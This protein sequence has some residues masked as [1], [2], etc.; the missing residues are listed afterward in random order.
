[1]AKIA[2]SKL[3]GSGKRNT[4]TRSKN[5]IEIKENSS[6]TES[7]ASPIRTSPRR[8]KLNSEETIATTSAEL[9]NKKRDKPSPPLYDADAENVGSRSE[10]TKN[11]RRNSGNL[12]EFTE[13]EAVLETTDSDSKKRS[14]RRK[15]RNDKYK[16]KTNSSKKYQIEAES[17]DN[18]MVEDYVE[19]VREEEKEVVEADQINEQA[20]NFE[21]DGYL[22]YD[23]EEDNGEIETTLSDEESAFHFG[24]DQDKGFNEKGTDDNG[25]DDNE[26]SYFDADVKNQY[27]SIK[28]NFNTSNSVKTRLSE[29]FKRQESTRSHLWNW[30]K[31]WISERVIPGAVE[32]GEATVEITKKAIKQISRRLVESS[33]NSTN[34]IENE[35]SNIAYQL[36]D[37]LMSQGIYNDEEEEHHG[38]IQE[39]KF[40]EPMAFMAMDNENENVNINFI[41]DKDEREMKVQELITSE[42]S[43]YYNVNEPLVN[44]QFKNYNHNY[45]KIERSYSNNSESHSKS[46]PMSPFKSSSSTSNFINS[47]ILDSRLTELVLF[48]A[49]CT[50]ETPLPSIYENLQEFF[51]LKGEHVLN[52]TEKQLVSTVMR[53]YL[54]ECDDEGIVV[55]EHSMIPEYN[56]VVLIQDAQKNENFYSVNNDNNSKKIKVFPTSGIRFKAPKFTIEEEARFEELEKFR[57]EQQQQQQQKF[58][59]TST[60]LKMRSKKLMTLQ[61]TANIFESIDVAPVRFNYRGRGKDNGDSVSSAIEDI[62]EQKV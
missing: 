43:S 25:T 41:A 3:Y 60:P 36:N 51:M 55:K 45:Q 21:I 40:E 4:P 46:S 33:T 27:P 32:L 58:S 11:D 23:Y 31:D 5:K 10:K 62:I 28:F 22:N 20:N 42:Q 14:N 18:E 35:T 39:L 15:S 47:D 19:S 16:P 29:Y 1:M 6:V 17:S 59:K 24:S 48:F 44:E 8:R 13:S 9:K 57:Q 26:I 53:E 37:E 34:E 7:Q 30:M 56:P 54:T 50:R 12:I 61:E 52:Y 2:S 49:K 38:N